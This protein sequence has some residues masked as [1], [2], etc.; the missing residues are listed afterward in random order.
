MLRTVGAVLLSVIFLLSCGGVDN[1]S[2]ALESLDLVAQGD[3]Q[4][5]PGPTTVV[6]ESTGIMWQGRPAE[7]WILWADA[8]D[9]C[10]D[11][12][13]EGYSDWRLPTINELRTLIVGCPGTVTGGTC[14][15]VGG[16]GDECYSSDCDGCGVYQGPGPGGCF[17]DAVWGDSCA[18]HWSSSTYIGGSM[19]SPT[20]Q[21][22][23]VEFDMGWIWSGNVND[24]HMVA[25]CVRSLP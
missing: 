21:A 18:H 17:M 20:T 6:D 16:C 1:S 15:V 25:R 7:D 22:W 19:F 12:I 13:L 24:H 10:E 5:G 11:L 4:V 2:D 23:Y 3:V 9:R 14:Q 8:V